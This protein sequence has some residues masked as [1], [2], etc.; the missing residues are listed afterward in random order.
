MPDLEKRILAVLARKNYQPLKPKALAR[1]LGISAAEYGRFRQALR[2]LIQQKRVEIGKNYTVRPVPPHGTVTGVYRGTSS[3]FGFVRPHALDGTAGPDIFIPA[4]RS[5]DAATGDTVLV[6]ITRKPTRPEL[7]PA[8]EI[9][10]VL[11]RATRQFV[12][13]YFEREGQGLVR[14]D[15]TVFSHSIDVGDPGAKGARPD[16]K[17]VFEMVRFPSSEDRGEGAITEVLGPRGQP[18]V[19]TLSIIRAFGLPDVFPE[20]ALEEARSQAA[21]FDEHERDGREDFS[22]ATIVTID[23]VDARD[24]DDAVSLVQDPRTKHW[25]LGVYIAD[26]E[27]FVPLGGPLDREARKRATS[28]YLPQRVLPM[29]PELI[30]NSLA[31]LQQGK[32]RYVKAALIDFT[33][34]GQKTSTRF[35]EGMIRVRR[36]F[37]YEQVSG[38]LARHPEDGADENRNTKDPDATPEILALLQRMRQLGMILRRRRMKRGALELDMPETELEYDNQ[39]RVIGAHFAKHDVSHQIIEEFMLAANEAVAEHL[40]GLGGPSLRR[41]HPPPDP[42]KLKAFADFVRTL[43]YKV[44][45]E[46]DRFTLQRILQQSVNKPDMYAV[47]YALLRSLKQAVYSPEEEGHYALASD[48][49]CHFTSPIRRY[50]DLTVHRQLAQWLRRKRVSADFAELAALGDH[51][52]KMERRAETAERE[53]IKLKLLSYFSD[54]IGMELEVIVTGVADYGF[55]GQGEEMP[56]EGL[57]HVSTLSD[58]YYYYDEA[59]HSL[60]G[61]RSQRRF[62]LGDKVRVRV[63]RVDLQRRQLDFRV[64]GGEKQGEDSEPSRRTRQRSQS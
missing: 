20:D 38:I 6:K 49:Y 44:E 46:T 52:S 30:S 37:T 42:N 41:V 23:P 15:G 9:I 19:D 40:A 29:F 27:H 33:P 21:A 35:A 48:T 64:S 18:G 25:Q 11:E 4:G 34:A 59:S 24:F 12:G 43:G 31:S 63:V 17:V 36:R 16:D 8:G 39:G 62:R 5:L 32:I 1:K 56:I 50:P 53:L 7:G 45:R 60:T 54:R 57:V 55:Y 58:D 2:Q 47:H 61:R 14:V 28:V 51:C 3:G 22:G 26:V 13:T 10:Q